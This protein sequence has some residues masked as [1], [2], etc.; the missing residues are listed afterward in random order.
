MNYAPLGTKTKAVHEQC[1]GR[2]HLGH[3][4]SVIGG[5]EIGHAHILEP[6]GLLADALNVLASNERFVVFN[7]RDAIMCHPLNDSFANA[8]TLASSASGD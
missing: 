4:A 5:I 2:N 6:P 8:D 1:E 7:L 3:A